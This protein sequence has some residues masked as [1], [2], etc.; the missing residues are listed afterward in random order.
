MLGR[1]Q[2]RQPAPE[3]VGDDDGDDIVNDVRL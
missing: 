1:D 2:L 3:Q